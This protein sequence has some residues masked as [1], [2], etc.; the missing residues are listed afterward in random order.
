MKKRILQPSETISH[1]ARLA[2][3]GLAL[4]EADRRFGPIGGELVAN[5][6]AE[7]KASGLQRQKAKSNEGGRARTRRMKGQIKGVKTPKQYISKLDEPRRADIAALDALIRK[8]APG[9]KPHIQAGMLAYGPF[10]YKYPSGREGDW[11]KIG[12]ASN[13]SYISLYACA[14]DAKG[15]VAERYRAK[16]PKAKI[17]KSCVTFKRLSD[18]DEKTLVAL[19]RETAKTGFG[20]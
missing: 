1:R 15:Y 16:L 7:L 11:F 3:L 2:A 9:L 6:H 19:I 8:H 10:R 5:A 17:G 4:A 13:K 12:V 14:A 18:L 20:M